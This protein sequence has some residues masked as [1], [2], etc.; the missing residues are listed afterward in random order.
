[1]KVDY[2]G[3]NFLQ[4]SNQ[5]DLVYGEIQLPADLVI[6]A[7]KRSVPTATAV[8]NLKNNTSKGVMSEPPPTPVKPY[9]S[10]NCKTRNNILKNHDK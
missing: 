9:Q 8:G 3:V 6:A 5:H 7:Y 2:Q 4:F 10:P 1:M